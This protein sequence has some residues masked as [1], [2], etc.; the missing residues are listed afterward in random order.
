MKII[1]QMRI[2]YTYIACV[3][4]QMFFFQNMLAAKKPGCDLDALKLTMHFA[5]IPEY[6]TIA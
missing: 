1:K 2:V 3:H 6:K 5:K 4:T